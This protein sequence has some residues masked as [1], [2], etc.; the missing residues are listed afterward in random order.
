M[1]GW[2][3]KKCKKTFPTIAEGKYHKC[4]PVKFQRQPKK[5]RTKAT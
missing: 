3:C 2:A 1:P 5:R 4:E